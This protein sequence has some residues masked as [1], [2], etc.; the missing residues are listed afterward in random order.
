[1][2]TF[3]NRTALAFGIALALA[4]SGASATN[5]YYTHGAGTK[6]KAQAGAGSANPEE[7]MELATNPAGITALPE[8]IDAGI[9]F[10]MP[11]RNYESSSSLYQGNCAPPGG[12]ANCACCAGTMTWAKACWKPAC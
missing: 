4:A 6:S 2:N 3:R 9:G 11:Y 8:S 5:G 7:I 12:P 1:M 10:F